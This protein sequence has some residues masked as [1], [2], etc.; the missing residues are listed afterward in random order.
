MTPQIWNS[1]LLLAMIVAVA[2]VGTGIGLIAGPGPGLLSAG[3]SVFACL[4]MIR[5]AIAPRPRERS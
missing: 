4:L 1:C 2:L 3:L 5:H